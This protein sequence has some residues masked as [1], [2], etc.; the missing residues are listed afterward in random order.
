MKVGLL[1]ICDGI[2]SEGK[3]HSLRSFQFRLFKGETVLIAGGS[4]LEMDMI[5]EILS[6]RENLTDGKVTVCGEVVSREGE[7]TAWRPHIV[8]IDNIEAVINTVSAADNFFICSHAEQPFFAADRKNK[9]IL[10]ELFR[11][12]DVCISEK[13]PVSEMSSLQIVLF[14]ILKQYYHEPEKV[15]L[16]DRRKISLSDT[17]FA[18]VY[19]LMGRLK[20]RGMTFVVLDYSVNPQW[21]MLDEIVLIKEAKTVLHADISLLT[22]KERMA[23]SN[24][25]LQTTAE[26]FSEKKR[27]DVQNIMQM[28]GVST[29]M[30][31]RVDLDLAPG[32]VA[33]ISYSK[34]DAARHFF[35]VLTGREGIE[36]GTFCIAGRQSRA[37]TVYE[38]VQEG[39][40][41]I[42]RF[43]SVSYLYKNMT[44]Y[45]NF[46]FRKGMRL[47]EIWRNRRYK[48]YLKKMLAEI[49]GYDVADVKAG[50][51]LPIELVRVKFQEQKL[52]RPKVLVCMDPFSSVDAG[53]RIEMRKQID[54]VAA[55]GTGVIL[56]SS[57]GPV[58][59]LR[60]YTQYILTNS[61]ELRRIAPIN[62]D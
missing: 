28:R 26:H 14:L 58:R 11:K 17:E 10:R 46:S 57:L 32:E 27:D 6:G 33:V 1:E 50:E 19:R 41:S 15:V 39:L 31:H 5:V 16:I 3:M 48:T 38:R 60:Q 24:E 34:Y 47:K 23:L 55:N 20:A 37:H 13:K 62:A 52:A 51:L 44:A 2:K 49:V 4:I 8:T 12:F 54:A 56:L 53:L 35:Q 45:E 25:N 42:D 22:E 43:G 7:M 21:D 29:F 36:T 18:E 9:A 61:G 40:D 30:L 59:R